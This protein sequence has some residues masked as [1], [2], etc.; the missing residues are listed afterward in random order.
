MSFVDDFVDFVA[1]AR[2]LFAPVLDPILD[3]VRSAQPIWPQTILIIAAL[4]APGIFMLSKSK[5]IT[6][7]F[8]ALMVLHAMLVNTYLMYVDIKGEYLGLFQ[9]DQFVGLMTMMFLAAAMLVI[10]ISPSYSEGTKHHGEYYGL[11]LAATAGMLFVSSASDLI[12]IFVGVE[13]AS[14]TSYALV[15][16]KKNDPRSSEAAVKYMII[17]G[18]STGLTLYGMS[19]IYGVVGSTDLA[20]IATAFAGG[21][22][23]WALAVAFVTLIAGFGFKISAVPFHMWAPDVYE[24]AATPV[25]AFLA[26]GSK[27]M[28]MIVFMKIF[29]LIF[30]GATVAPTEEIQIFFGILAAVTMTVGN[31]VAISQTNIKRMLAYSSI[32]QAGYLMIMF[33]VA[34]EF[35]LAAGMF[36]MIT[37]VFMKGG[38][39]IIVAALI[40][41]GLGE[42]ISDYRGLAKR[43]P[44]VAFAMT[45][46]LF[47]L[48]GIPPLAGFASKFFLFSSAINTGVMSGTWVWLVTIAVIN[49]AISLYYYAKVVKAMVVDE[50]EETKKIKL[51]VSYNIAIAACVFFVILMGVLPGFFLEL[52]ETAASA[53]W[54]YI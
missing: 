3:I 32:A 43:A 15:A 13:L 52:C 34:T 22:F 9:Y 45:L 39:F 28:G 38:A 24:G 10:L 44:W 4:I 8:A 50:G 33:A 47:S 35:A 12:T 11:I 48:A 27:K 23:T 25:S 53:F 21:D 14:I 18:I 42:N 2:E 6:A 20:A 54:A 36:H 17:G 40:T 19:L 16:L 29:L 49:S 30:I 7:A 5:K 46:F 37:H 26:T 41:K 1:P 31:V 51:P